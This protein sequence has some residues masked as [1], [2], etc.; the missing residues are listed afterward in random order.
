MV[1]SAVEH[2]PGPGGAPSCWPASAAAGVAMGARRSG[3]VVCLLGY[4][5][6]GVVAGQRS[7]AELPAPLLAWFEAELAPRAPDAVTW[8]VGRLRRDAMP[9]RLWRQPPGRGRRGQTGAGGAPDAR[10]GA[11]ERRRL[12]GRWPHRRVASGAHGAPPG[13]VPASGAL[14]E[15]GSPDQA[16]RSQVRGI[17]LLGSVT[18]ALQVEVLRKGSLGQEW[19]SAARTFVRR[20]RLQDGRSA[21]RPVRRHRHRGPHRRSGRARP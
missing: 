13:E 11:G 21:R 1:V 20:G 6:A 10:C 15:P 19:S 5:L 9:T 14:R 17:D 12:A 18:S 16:H 4:A 3:A 2:R 7:R 8:V